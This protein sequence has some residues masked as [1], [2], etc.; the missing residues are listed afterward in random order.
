MKK[1]LV[2]I[3]LLSLS[4][5]HVQADILTDDQVR[6]FFS[7]NGG[8]ILEV[9]TRKQLH[10]AYATVQ[11]A[12]GEMTKR[13]VGPDLEAERTHRRHLQDLIAS[14]LGLGR[15]FGGISTTQVASAAERRTAIFA[16]GGL[17][18]N[19]EIGEDAEG[20]LSYGTYFGTESKN[21]GRNPTEQSHLGTCSH[22]YDLWFRERED[23]PPSASGSGISYGGIVDLINTTRQADQRLYEKDD[24]YRVLH[25]QSIYRGFVDKSLVKESKEMVFRQLRKFYQNVDTYLNFGNLADTFKEFASFELSS[26]FQG[27]LEQLYFYDDDSEKQA[28]I[29]NTLSILLSNKKIRKTFFQK[30]GMMWKVKSKTIDVLEGI[31]LKIPFCWV[32]RVLNNFMENLKNCEGFGIEEGSIFDGDVLTAE[33]KENLETVKKRALENYDDYYYDPDDDRYHGYYYRDVLFAHDEDDEDG[34]GGDILT[35]REGDSA[36][37]LETL[38]KQGKER[39]TEAAG[40]LTSGLEQSPAAAAN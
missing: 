38:E 5:A 15:G 30:T 17:A 1:Y 28:G 23:L 24:T 34:F 20:T 2:R 37:D 36:V 29:E 11:F 10:P 18:L 6:D 9:Q 40:F 22:I 13:Q 32:T 25:P 21:T 19:E 12:L 16:L 31:R 14:I 7:R 26:R 8:A 3:A 35:D 27:A 33:E 39:P 4:A